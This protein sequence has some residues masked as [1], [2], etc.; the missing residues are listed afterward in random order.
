MFHLHLEL[1]LF[2]FVGYFIHLVCAMTILITFYRNYQY[3]NTI[4][5]IFDVNQNQMTLTPYSS[6]HSRLFLVSFRVQS[7]SSVSNPTSF[8]FLHFLLLSRVHLLSSNISKYLIQC[9]FWLFQYNFVKFCLILSVN[10]CECVCMLKL[11]I[12]QLRQWI[13]I[14]S[15]N[16]NR[17]IVDSIHFIVL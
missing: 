15:I 13:L 3:Y 16:W 10:V 8:Y 9:F 17:N 4:S 11:K 6:H 12:I 1:N 14:Q 5:A 7:Q 2:V